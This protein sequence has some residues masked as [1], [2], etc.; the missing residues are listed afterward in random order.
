MSAKK[1]NILEDELR[2][3][4]DICK[5]NYQSRVSFGYFELYIKNF[6][7]RLFEMLDEVKFK[8]MDITICNQMY[9]ETFEIFA[10]M[11]KQ[12]RSK[13]SCINCKVMTLEDGENDWSIQKNL[14]YVLYN[15]IEE[16]FRGDDDN[17]VIC[18]NV[19]LCLGNYINQ[20]NVR[21]NTYKK[22]V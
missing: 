20:I 1:S 18:F 10:T 21:I 9:F 3:S 7:E 12:N 2:E 22:M 15:K 13:L 5:E 11:I 17:N 6:D 8:C 19:G 14:K 16:L 4:F